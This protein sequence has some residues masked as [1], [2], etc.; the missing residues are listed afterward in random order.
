VAITVLLCYDKKDERMVRK[1]K[2]QL[3]LL[4][5]N[6][7]IAL[8]DDADIA[9]GAD[10]EQEM[11]K[12]L[13]EAQVIL[14]LISSSFLGSKYPYKIGMQEAIQK[15]EQKKARVIPILLS[16]V[17]WE[18]PPIA[19]LQPLPDSARPITKWRPQDEGYKN[20]ADGIKRVVDQ[21]NAQNLADLSPERMAF[22]AIFERFTRAVQSQL[23]PAPRAEATA[24]TLRELSIL[25]PNDVELAD[26][27]AGW[28]I[29]ARPLQKDE[30][31][32]IAKRRI[33]CG[34]LASIVAQFS[35]DQG[36]IASA[37]RAWGIW[38]E[39]FRYS[40]DDRQAAMAETFARELAELQR[41]TH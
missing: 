19:N 4:V 18:E 15:H 35:Q 23:Q 1:L 7:L 33:T 3:S 39:A 16:P 8:W 2:N 17:H 11:N 32:N 27:S 13:D 31:I 5:R 12:S 36:K 38:T 26:L 9:P 40:G 30:A 22:V 37:I 29:L 20:V 25:I 21:W 41:A 24:K 6:G 10:R 28:R 34:E 14:L